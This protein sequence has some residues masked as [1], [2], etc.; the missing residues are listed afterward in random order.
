MRISTLSL[1][2]QAVTA[3]LDQQ[4]QLARTQLQVA[5]GERILSPSDDPIGTSRALNLEQLASQL[6]QY[7]V[8]NN[9]LVNRLSLS[10]STL[11]QV[12]NVLQRVRELAIQ[13]NNDTQSAEGRRLIAAEVRELGDELLSLANAQNGQGEYLYSGFRTSTQA[14][15]RTDA[16]VIYNGDQGQRL[17]QIGSDRTVADGNPG[18]AIFQFVPS[19]NGR[20]TTTAAAGNTGTGI[21]ATG[22]VV[23]T[24][25]FTPDNYVINFLTAT[26]YEVVDSGGAT[27]STGTYVDGNTIEFLGTQVN[28]SGAPDPGDSFGVNPSVNTPLFSTI[29]NLAANLEQYSDSPAGRAIFHSGLNASIDN[30]D[31]GIGVVLNVRTDLGSR[32][33][34]A[35]TQESLNSQL[36]IDL[37]ATISE[38]RDLD[39]AEAVSRLNI[40]LTGLQAAQQAFARVQNLSLFNFLR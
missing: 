21:I 37:Q 38:I 24:A 6:E 34:S 39:Y 5:T 26:D 8:N 2:Q 9:L 17:L 23:D 28:I 20:F 18:T 15:R 12:T 30:L 3:I 14:F 35:E 29:D 40:Q 33:T 25:L 11:T 19:G 16:G 32:L 1:Q 13:A 31:Q 22:S 7:E 36:S 10:E 27:V 4:R